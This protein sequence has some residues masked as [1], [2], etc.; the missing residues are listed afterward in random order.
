MK[1]LIL[2]IV[3]LLFIQNVYGLEEKTYN[4]NSDNYITNYDDKI[5]YCINICEDKGKKFSETRFDVLKLDNIK[6]YIHFGYKYNSQNDIKYY[7]ATQNLIWETLYGIEIK[8]YENDNL[9]DFIKEENDIKN[10]IKNYNIKPS[11]SEKTII[12]EYKT[13]NE[14]IDENN[15]LNNYSTKDL[16]EIKNN[17]LIINYDWVGLKSVTLVHKNGLNET[18]YYTDSSNKYIYSTGFN[19]LITSVNLKS[20]IAKTTLKIN[21]NGDK[22]DNGKIINSKIDN[23][24]QI[25]AY[26]DIYDI[27]GELLYKK[28]SLVLESKSNEEFMLNIGNYYIKEKNNIEGYLKDEKIYNVELN[29][30]K[31]ININKKLLISNT[32]FESNSLEKT[33]KVYNNEVAILELNNTKINTYLPYGKYIISD[34]ITSKQFELNNIS[35]HLL[36]LDENNDFIIQSITEKEVKLESQ[37]ILPNTINNLKQIEILIIIFISVGTVL[38][39]YEK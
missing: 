26:E 6:Q 31:E 7:Y 19:S 36:I 5:L 21:V 24:Y 10:S 32:I 33:Y 27:Y 3:S 11:F 4:F 35:Y 20:K 39:K 8:W 2:F 1:K 12:G 28:D 25:Y 14:I 23:I 18:K 15:V 29:E 16:I 30:P 34:G 17:K 9:I 13:T 22:Y 38:L 37:E